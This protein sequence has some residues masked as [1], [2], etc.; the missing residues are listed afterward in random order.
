MNEDTNIKTNRITA[1]K[2]L[3]IELIISLFLA[4]LLQIFYG[5][6]PAYSALLGGLAYILPNAY[7][8]RYAFKES[9][10]ETPDTIVYKFYAG[11]AGKFILTGVIFAI[12]F[13][14]VRP[15]NVILLFVTYILMLIVNQAGLGLNKKELIKHTGEQ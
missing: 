12:C 14:T 15:L 10:Q 6:V 13:A 1:Y 7:F 3:G 8:V 9:G 2:L 4:F 5:G 11:E